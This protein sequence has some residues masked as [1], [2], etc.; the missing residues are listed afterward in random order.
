MLVLTRKNNESIV[1]GENIVMTVIEVR[2]DRVQLGFDAPKTV[3]IH[4][5]ELYEEIRRV[6]VLK[7]GNVAA[8]A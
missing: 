3:S 8:E 6:G 2:G 7:E 1:I 5:R 4:R